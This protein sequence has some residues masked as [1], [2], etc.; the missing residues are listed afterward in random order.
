M[1]RREAAAAA[2]A[3]PG[4]VGSPGV[5]KTD[6]EN[7][8]NDAGEARLDSRLP[9][10]WN[11]L[12]GGNFNS[13]PPTAACRE[14]WLLLSAESGSLEWLP[15][16]ERYCELEAKDGEEKVAA[17]AALTSVRLDVVVDS[18]RFCGA[19]PAN[20][21]GFAM[22]LAALLTIGTAA[23]GPAAASPPLS[24]NAAAAAM[25]ESS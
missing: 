2:A 6:G 1:L 19:P 20:R 22:R 4:R 15:S 18:D 8:P 3:N 12:A 13:A 25:S 10:I 7:A 14:V 21:G 24:R 11:G 16:A 5:A 9:S 23:P 17:T